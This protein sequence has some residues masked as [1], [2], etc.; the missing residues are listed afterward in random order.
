MCLSLL[1][2]LVPLA[3]ADAG[4]S[5]VLSDFE[6]G[7]VGW[8]TNDAMKYSGQSQDT[9][10]VSIEAS[11]EAHA[12]SG[13]AQITFHPGQ[14]W[15][16]AYI[17]LASVRDQLTDAR[18][19]EFAFWMKGDGQDV[20]VTVHIQAWSDQGVPAF[21]GVPVSLRQTTWHQVVIPLAQFQAANPAVP[22]RVPNFHAFQFDG[23]G[24]LGPASL[25]IDDLIA[26]NARDQGG[27][28][29]SGPELLEGKLRSL[30]PARGLPRWGMWGF[31]PLTPEGLAVSRRLGLQFGSNDET[32]LQQQIAFTEGL[33]SNDC[34]GR[35]G[36]EVLAGLGFTDEDLDQDAEGHPMGE[37][38]RSAVFA[39]EV[40][41][42]FCRHVGD[43]VASRRNAPWVGSFML[44]SPI[45]MY[46]E[47]HYS[48]ST[49]GQYAVFS[50]PA[51]AN[52]RAWL[53]KQYHGDLKALSRAWG[54]TVSD[55]EAIDPPLGPANTEGAGIDTRT[56]WSDFMHW[57][58]GWL[59]EVTRRSLEA[60]REQTDKP[61]AVMMGGPK[62]GLSQGIALG[63]IGPIVRLLGKVRPA[64]LS[65]TD[66]QT[67]FSCRYTRAACSQYGVDLM[68]EHVGPPY[69][70]RFHQYNMALNILACGAD[71]GHLAQTGQLY[72][73]D[74]WF[75]PTWEA[76]A[77]L[78][79]QYRTGY[80]KSD[81]ALLH[82][83]VTSWYRPERSNGDCVRL[84]DATN[85]LWFPENGYPSWGRA[86]GSPDVVDDAMVEDG[87]LK[88]RKLLVIPNSS[89]VITTRKA[90][91]ALSAW[92]RQGG[93]VVGFGEGC[94]AYTVEPDR[95]VRA[96]PGIAGLLRGHIPAEGLPERLA[97]KVGRGRVVLFRNPTVDGP[98]LREAVPLLEAEADRAGVRRW[99][100]DD[101]EGRINPMYAGRE[102]RSGK[103]LF[104]VDLT[105]SV[106][107]DPPEAEVDFW[108]DRS[109]ELTFDPSLSG[110]AELVGL[111]NSFRRCRGGR[112]EFDPGSHILRIRFR[113]PGKL[114]L[115]F[116]EAQEAARREAP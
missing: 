56:T 109:F 18:I 105:R 6:Q 61:L 69:L 58:N 112:A 24:E 7:P 26:R 53:R 19:D 49:T 73:P 48:A 47:V 2:L 116:G 13:G 83:Y 52:F 91:D 114:A 97:V 77:P 79:L 11:A 94:L 110:D 17:P 99:C 95:S 82:S 108:T 76:L 57:Y 32:R 12:G 40:L 28:F 85:T 4:Q 5:L 54:E 9:P 25:W 36:S 89:V 78:V 111:T 81:A 107:N 74:H 51:R 38:V 1:L 115:V 64:F 43:A 96:T 16:G 10:L 68:L 35:P 104:V 21:W 20:E 80:V 62:I 41:E 87:A 39:P 31:V 70:H 113:L 23:S 46:G 30:P 102:A 59:E 65:D 27:P 8:V 14:G 34:P 88:G 106:R 86:L 15:A 37:G 29:A 33:V 98:F 93:T 44:S 103:H 55:W 66:S 84:Y 90:V 50:R 100:R 45:S 3:P 60:A 67:L 42:R 101:G 75:G 63:N 22:L 71:A 72:D 92:V